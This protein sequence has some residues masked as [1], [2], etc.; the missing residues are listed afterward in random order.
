MV[1]SLSEFVIEVETVLPGKEGALEAG[2]VTV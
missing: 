2:N 1:T